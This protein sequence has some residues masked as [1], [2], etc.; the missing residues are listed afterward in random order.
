MKFQFSCVRDTIVSFALYLK[1]WPGRCAIWTFVQQDV[2]DSG[3]RDFLYAME[4]ADTEAWNRIHLIF[5]DKKSPWDDRA[6]NRSDR[7]YGDDPSHSTWTDKAW[8]VSDE[9]IHTLKLTV[10]KDYISHVKFLQGAE[11]CFFTTDVGPSTAVCTKCPEFQA[12]GGP[13]RVDSNEKCAECEIG[14]AVDDRT[15]DC[16]ICAAGTFASNISNTCQPCP[17]GMYTNLPGQVS[18]LPCTLD[19]RYAL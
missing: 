15:K 5:D 16:S 17:V 11:T 7:I 10:E 18:C 4:D 9:R 1:K 3:I 14:Y 8:R 2:D 19:T 6:W 13:G 12:L